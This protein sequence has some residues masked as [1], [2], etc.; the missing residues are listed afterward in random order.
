[1]WFNPIMSFIL[2]SPLHGMLGDTM[3]VTVTG[4][5]TG[6]QYTTPVGF[7]RDGNC[8]WILSSKDRTWWRNL[9]ANPHVCIRLYGKEVEGF[10]EVLE[11]EEVVAA[12]LQDYLRHIPM[13]ARSFGIHVEDGMINATDAA[14]L[15]KERLF[16]RIVLE[17]RA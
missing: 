9:R 3:L 2:R 1:M 7:Y 5:K 10:A 8:L 4:R 6:K 14:R 13:A 15:A 11:E 17:R 12:Q 16:V